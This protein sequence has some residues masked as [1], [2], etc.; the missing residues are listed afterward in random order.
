[1]NHVVRA[2][3]A[4]VAVLMV[5]GCLVSPVSSSGGLGAVTVINSNPNSIIAALQNEFSQ[6]G[7][8]LSDSNYPDSVS[9]DKPAGA[10]GNAMWGSYGAPQSIRVKVSIVPIPGTT[11]YRLEP[12]VY[13]VTD[14]GEAGFDQQRPLMGL[15]N[16]EFGP[17]LKR[18][19]KQASF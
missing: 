14:A 12:R 17:L 15:W 9:F 8:T 5:G 16:A 11:N 13:S 2:F 18:A 1:M 7:Y 10:F 6:N 3:F 19:A 4:F